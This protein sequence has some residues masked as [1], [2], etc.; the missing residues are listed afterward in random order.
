MLQ[1]RTCEVLPF[2]ERDLIRFLGYWADRSRVTFVRKLMVYIVRLVAI[3][4]FE[5][6]LQKVPQVVP[7]FVPWVVPQ[8]IFGLY[9]IHEL[10]S[11]SQVVLE[12]VLGCTEF[13]RLYLILSLGLYPRQCLG[14]TQFMSCTHVL[15][16]YLSLSQVVPSSPGCA[17]FCLLGLILDSYWIVSMSLGVLTFSSYT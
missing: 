15:K 1:S 2:H 12:F 16:L 17:W 10:Y 6:V 4:L 9:P 7:G 3:F 5:V 14:Y 8:T 11:C 13:Y